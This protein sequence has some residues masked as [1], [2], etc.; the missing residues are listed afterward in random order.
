[1][2][3][4]VI[5]TYNRDSAFGDTVR[6]FLEIRSD[7]IGHEL[8]LMDNNSTDRTR[9]IG[10]GFASQYPWIRYVNEPVQGHPHSKNRAIR[11]SRGEIV[12]FVDDDVYFS[13]GWLKAIASCFERHPGVSC[14]GGRVVPHFEVDRPTWIEDE[15]LWIYGVTRYG[16]HERE[17]LPPEI[18]I[19]CNM[20]FRRAVFETIGDFHTA[21]GRKPG[22]LLSGDEDHFLH[23]LTKAGFRTLYSPDAQVS[24]RVPASRACRDWVVDRFY[25][26]G[27]S[28]VAM[29]QFGD[30]RLS[31]YILSK[32]AYWAMRGILRQWRDAP[33]LLGGINGTDA[34]VP[35]SRQTYLYH[36]LGTLR[37]LIAEVFTGRGG[38]YCIGRVTE[39]GG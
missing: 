7:A 31:R 38:N 5:C 22:I 16:E 13:P 27:I 26:A 39:N 21:L 37:Q 6:S 30:E 29:R 15:M 12:A 19:G 8:L 10:E 24:H 28:E 3:S 33:C 23:R 18:P 1:L 36:R 35:V 34:K 17:I 25:W 32:Q 2:I 14:I 20:A 11:E 9:E 4:V